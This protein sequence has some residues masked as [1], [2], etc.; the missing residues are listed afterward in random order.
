[1]SL[2]AQVRDRIDDQRRK[3]QHWRSL[4]QVRDDRHEEVADAIDEVRDEIDHMRELVPK[5]EKR[6]LG[7]TD[8]ELHK[9]RM[10]LRH[11]IVDDLDTLDGLLKRLANVKEM[12]DK[13]AR[14]LKAHKENLARAERKLK[15]LKEQS[16]S[17]AATTDLIVIFDTKQVPSWMVRDA[18]EPARASGTWT[19]VVIS[20]FRTPEDS[21]GLCMD[22]CGAASCPGKCGG[23]SSNHSCPPTHTGAPFEG[24]VDVT[25]PE[26]LQ[27]WCAA[28]GFPIIHTLSQDANHFSRTGA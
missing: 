4:E 10:E 27:R 13:A 22:M 25:D 16:E 11:A 17:R 3:V 6:H 26:G 7:W 2:K 15:F 1:M 9:R 23:A 28:N 18:L 5:L 19:G 8:A 12:S 24:A 21:I 14:H 20:G